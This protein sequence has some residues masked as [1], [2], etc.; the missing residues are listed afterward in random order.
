M[1]NLLKQ[2]KD[3]W[4]QSQQRRCEIRSFFHYLP[5]EHHPHRMAFLSPPSCSHVVF[6]LAFVTRTIR[7]PC[8]VGVKDL[9][10]ILAYIPKTVASR[11]YVIP[12]IF[13]FG[14]RECIALRVIWKLLFGLVFKP[15]FCRPFFRLQAELGLRVPL[16]VT[17][18][19]KQSFLSLISTNSQSQDERN[20]TASTG[21]RSTTAKQRT[22]NGSSPSRIW[23]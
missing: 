14:R 7:V 18:A 1:V 9:S 20:M 12:S 11:S 17:R 5:A 15:Q 10:R 16:L 19:L 21:T 23:R 3:G 4:A 6:F 22:T 2:A 13:T 8:I